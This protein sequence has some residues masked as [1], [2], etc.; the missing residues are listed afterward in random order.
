MTAE[1]RHHSCDHCGTPFTPSSPDD[2]FC[3]EGC[4]FVHDLIEGEGLGKFYELRGRERLLPAGPS[5]LLPT[6]TAWAEEIQAM[7]ES[8][9][10]G[11]VAETRLDLQGVSCMG[12]VWLI[13]ALF[14]QQ[15]GAGRLFV[16]A[17][18]GEVTLS[19]AIEEFDL[20]A[21]VSRLASF[22]YLLGLPTGERAASSAASGLRLGLAGGLALN[23]M[24]FT[25][26]RYLGMEE[27]FALAGV[28]ELIAAA[29]ATLSLLACGSYFIA[30]AGAALRLRRLH[31][32]VPISLGIIA[33]WLGSMI[34]WF[35]GHPSLLYFDFV[36]TFIFLMLLG[37]RWQEASVSRHRARLLRADPLM[38]QV[39]VETP[40]TATG[41]ASRRVSD[42][43]RGDV[44]ALPSGAVNPVAADLLDAAGSLSL[45][46]ITGE[47]EPRAWTA[48]GIIP[49]GAVNLGRAALRLRAREDWA[50]SFLAKLSA[51][52]TASLDDPAT[53]RTD[54]LLRVYL[55]VVIILALAGGLAWAGTTDWTRG[56]Q[57]FISVLV[58]SCPCALGVALPLAH[59]LAVARMRRA[60]LF[61]RRPDLW[62]RLRHVKRVI[63]DKTGTLTMEAPQLLHPETLDALRPAV[64]QALAHLVRESRHPLSI[65]LRQAMAARRLSPETALPAPALP[66]EYPGE[67]LVWTAPDGAVWS[68]GRHDWMPPG[69]T[70]P[71]GG[72]VD[73]HQADVVLRCDGVSV[74]A[75]FF[76]EASRPDAFDELTRLRVRGYRIN[77]LSG[78][79]AEKVES[80]ARLIGLPT[81]HA[82]ARLSPEAKAAWIH[83]NAPDALFIGDGANDSLAFDAALVRGTPAIE[84]GLLTEKA[85]F[86]FLS[87]GIR[88]VRQLLDTARRHRHAVLMAFS[89]ALAYNLAV[90]ALAL[91]GR[92]TPLLAAILMPLSSLATLLLVAW[93]L[94]ER[95]AENSK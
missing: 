10:P 2:R 35:S 22:G 40:D 66:V 72:F 78:D 75:F 92:M 21:F 46:W 28:F 58:V 86:Y 50:D 55:G 84:R 17:Q 31:L 26:P 53:R 24:A 9:A 29:S 56:L 25:L 18:R 90:L 52:T 69:L 85:D 12:C 44:F 87:R 41:R 83:A 5:V 32:D 36:A 70:P 8:K 4:A 88:P 81:D 94:T 54:R 23:A 95:E 47:A 64:R 57:V 65:S 42:L 49:P 80:F 19:W 48:G 93:N 45:E 3:C 79:R 68:L 20:P 67:G 51:P 39:S 16:N 77:V 59:E 89:F 37:R 74:A 15:P 13:E 27:S 82:R 91:S 1:L 60:G 7:A 14:Q 30:R 34:G 38:Q 6:Q 73:D 33:A 11:G 61:V 63:F 71:A 43:Q 62:G 76:T